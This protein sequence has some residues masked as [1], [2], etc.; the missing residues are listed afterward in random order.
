MVNKCSVRVAKS[1][2]NKDLGSSYQGWKPP[3]VN[4]HCGAVAM[5]G[6]FLSGLETTTAGRAY[7]AAL[8]LG[9][10][11]QTIMWLTPHHRMDENGVEELIHSF[12]GW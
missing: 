3:L 4:S 12:C 1:Q 5:F 9:S 6:I 8:R 11:Y 10:S 2:C 7:A